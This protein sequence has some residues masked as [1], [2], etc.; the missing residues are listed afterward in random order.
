MKIV[1]GADFVPTESNA[2]HFSRGEVQALFDCKMADYLNQPSYKIFNLEMPLTN[3]ST[4]IMKNGPALVARKDTINLYKK[5]GVNLLTLANNHIMDQGV[6][7]LESTISLLDASGISYIGAG[8]NICSAKKAVIF[9]FGKYKVGVYACVEHEFSVAGIRTPGANPFDPLESFDHVSLLKQDCDYVIVLYHGG[10]ELYRYPSPDLQRYCR[11]FV[12]KGA[13]LVV[14]QHSHCI[15]CKEE[16]E[17]GT[18]VYG[19]GNFLFDHSENEFWKTGLLIEIDE[20][21]QISYVPVLKNGCSVQLADEAQAGII[22]EEFNY[23]GKQIL[24]EDFIQQNYTEFAKKMLNAYYSRSLGRIR[25]NIIFKI[26]N[27]LMKSSLVKFCYDTD[28]DLAMLNY[29]ECEAHREL[30][31]E[32]L[33]ASIYKGR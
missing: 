4:P 20:G 32:G 2:Q 21:F 6:Q 31:A 22:L 1:I 9:G 16:Y 27:K 19:Q 12:Q 15:G 28:S 10:K 8:D 3:K 14:C 24:E 11:K 33:R 26:I 5:I 17:E 18:I 23:R 13:D 7:G 29:I 25:K 30:F